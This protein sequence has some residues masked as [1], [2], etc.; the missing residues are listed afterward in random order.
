MT[1]GLDAAFQSIRREFESSAADRARAARADLLRSLR[2]LMLRFR[3]YQG[4]EEWVALVL[5]AASRFVPTAAL[6]GVRGNNLELRGERGLNLPEHLTIE[7]SSA[8][9]MAA[10]IASKDVVFALRTASEFGAALHAPESN[11]RG[12]AV[13]IMNGERVVALLFSAFESASDNEALELVAG[14]ASIVLERQA[15][16]AVAVQITAAANPPPSEES[17]AKLPDW[18]DLSDEERNLQV[19]AQRFARIKVAELQLAH[20][21][22]A[23]AGLQQNNVYLFLKNGIDAA[24]ETYRAQFMRDKR[25]IDYLHLELVRAAANGEET[26]LGEEY[27]GPLL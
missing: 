14:M 16:S 2:E 25:M 18:H 10:V 23:R 27:P 5:D 26:K 13:P 6:F 1:D 15:N 8:A 24:R 4:E 3:S 7:T 20:P 21:D 19:R 17:H 11:A 22:S 12:F 9:A